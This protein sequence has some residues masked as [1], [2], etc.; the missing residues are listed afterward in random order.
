MIIGE[1]TPIP[2]VSGALSDI[3]AV[4]A[5]LAA[6]ASGPQDVLDLPPDTVETL[7]SIAQGL[8]NL[9]KLDVELAELRLKAVRERLETTTNLLS[10]A[11]PENREAFLGEVRSLGKEIGNIGR[12][13]G[14]L[15]GGAGLY[16][17][18]LDINA[19]YLKLVNVEE[20]LSVSTTNEGGLEITQT[21]EVTQLVASELSISRTQTLL[22]GSSLSS[23]PADFSSALEGL[24]SGFQ[25]AVSGF[26]DLAGAFLS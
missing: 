14:Q 15:L 26:N 11:L 21:R 23:L 18:T 2:A 13:I 6:R 7:K 3:P 12:Q 8:E 22:G 1:G 4:R 24:V 17:E 20:S 5:T 25:G 19:S 9:R 16:S 10:R